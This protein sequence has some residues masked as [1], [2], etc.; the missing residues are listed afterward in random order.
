MACYI[1]IKFILIDPNIKYINL[2]LSHNETNFTKKEG[3]S[4]TWVIYFDA[5]PTPEIEW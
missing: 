2:T 5:F 1:S 3:D 4:I